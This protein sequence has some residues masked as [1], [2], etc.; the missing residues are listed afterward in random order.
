MKNTKTIEKMASIVLV[1]W[2]FLKMKNFT[3]LEGKRT[4]LLYMEKI[5]AQLK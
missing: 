5:L 2:D 1:T 4:S 3:L